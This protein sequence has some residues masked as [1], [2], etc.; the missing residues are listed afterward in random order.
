MRLL[1][2]SASYDTCL[3]DETISRCLQIHRVARG[4]AYEAPTR[5]LVAMKGIGKRLEIRAY[6]DL[7]ISHHTGTGSF[8]FPAHIRAFVPLIR[9]AKKSQKIIARVATFRARQCH[10]RGMRTRV[11][12]RKAKNGSSGCSMMKGEAKGMGLWVCCRESHYIQSVHRF[13]LPHNGGSGLMSPSLS[14]SQ[15]HK[16]T[17]LS[18]D[19]VT[20]RKGRAYYRSLRVAEAEK[21]SSP[22]VGSS[23]AYFRDII[24]VGRSFFFL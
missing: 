3:D 16:G 13:P 21:L 17:L 19:R 12:E 11:D 14:G 24:R 8:T 7:L 15:W 18:R 4:R 22:I 1:R 9:L 5:N 23:G 20:P 10:A 2:L 6:R